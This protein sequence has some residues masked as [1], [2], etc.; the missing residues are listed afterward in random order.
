MVARNRWFKS[1]PTWS[2]LPKIGSVRGPGGRLLVEYLETE[3]WKRV[4][5]REITAETSNNKIEGNEKS[6]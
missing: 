2:Q 6:K 3:L 4:I 1:F 5:M